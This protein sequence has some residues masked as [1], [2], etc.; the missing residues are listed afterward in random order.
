VDFELPGLGWK[1]E[2]RD[3]MGKIQRTI[4]EEEATMRGDKP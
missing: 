4:G 2:K 1:R 3:Q